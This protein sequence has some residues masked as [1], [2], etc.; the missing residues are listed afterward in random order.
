MPTYTFYDESSGIEW[1]DFMSIA[2]KEKFLLENK[3]ITQV[4]KPVAIAG[5]HLMGV[6]PKTDGGF[7]ENMQRIAAAHPGS[8]LADKFGGHGKSHKEIKTRNVLKKHGIKGT[9]G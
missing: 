9:K 2:D 7:K 4:P 8:P 5:A 6:G 1:D 3:Q